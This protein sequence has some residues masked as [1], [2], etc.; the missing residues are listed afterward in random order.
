[1]IETLTFGAC[2]HTQLIHGL[3]YYLDLNPLCQIMYTNLN[4]RYIKRNEIQCNNL[5]SRLVLLNVVLIPFYIY[6]P[7]CNF[8]ELK[9]LTIVYRKYVSLYMISAVTPDEVSFRFHCHWNTRITRTWFYHLP[10]SMNIMTRQTL[11]ENWQLIWSLFTKHMCPLVS[12]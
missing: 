5:N 12:P 3:V 2:G 9:D 6:F 1:M 10:P 4:T 8:F 11:Y 7:Q